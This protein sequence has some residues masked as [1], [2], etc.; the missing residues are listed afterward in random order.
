MG[1]A[2]TASV[3]IAPPSERTMESAPPN[4]FSAIEDSKLRMYTSVRGWTAVLTTVVRVRS[5]SPYSCPMSEEI[6]TERSGC[7][8][9]AMSRARRSCAGFT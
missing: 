1:R 6:E 4:S 3:L 8:S 2:A 5:Y 9:R 7:I